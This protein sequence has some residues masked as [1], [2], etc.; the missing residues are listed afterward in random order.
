MAVKLLAKSHDKLTSLSFSTT[1]D[2]SE[3]GKM[4]YDN[5]GVLL[6][7][8]RADHKSVMSISK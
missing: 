7:A 8:R 5:L 3:A 6:G 2:G 4:M 1:I